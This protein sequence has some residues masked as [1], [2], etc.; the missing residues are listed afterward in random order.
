MQC[1]NSMSAGCRC[2][3]R[4]CAVCR[5]NV[6]LVPHCQLKGLLGLDGQEKGASVALGPCVHAKTHPG[7]EWIPNT[8]RAHF[9][10][11]DGRCSCRP[12]WRRRWMRQCMWTEP[13]DG[14]RATRV[15]SWTL[16]FFSTRPT[17]SG[18]LT[19]CGLRAKLVAVSSRIVGRGWNMTNSAAS[20]IS[21]VRSTRVSHVTAP[22]MS[23][24]YAAAA[25]EPVVT[26]SVTSLLI[27]RL[28]VT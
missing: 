28:L 15:Q 10:T 6:C 18:S 14:G 5:E 7:S 17:V 1:E 23:T 9:C 25:C 8:T 2:F 21:W 22:R 3:L 11:S 16:W 20:S 13:S 19:V 26:E 4:R 12:P 27:R 24:S